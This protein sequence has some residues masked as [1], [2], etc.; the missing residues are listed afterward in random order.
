MKAGKSG[1]ELG[2][3]GEIKAF[4]KKVFP[5]CWPSKCR[6]PNCKHPNEVITMKL[7]HPKLT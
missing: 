3:M 2:E 6:L 7:S 5:L 1:F 4:G